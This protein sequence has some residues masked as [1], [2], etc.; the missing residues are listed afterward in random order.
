MDLTAHRNK[1]IEKARAA[2]LMAILPEDCGA[3]ALDVGAR[4][5]WYS[6]LL[7][8]RFDKVTALDLQM[9]NIR[10]PKIECVKGN[11]VKLDFNDGEFELIFCTE[12][13]EHIPTGQLIKVCSEIERV[14]SKYIIIGVPFKQDIRVARTKCYT[15]G[16]R[17]PPWGHINSFDE[18]YLRN[19]FSKCDVKKISF[20][21]NSNECT[22]TLSVFLMDFAGNPYGTYHQE[23]P[24][25]W[26][27][28]NLKKPP[29]RTI[30]QKISTK[31][32]FFIQNLQ[33]T[34]HRSHPNWIHI[35]FK[36]RKA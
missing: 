36:K 35:L 31:M 4:D 34:F 17:N 15:C 12:V 16:K 33:K 18:N 9:P 14:A 11:A 27:G 2:D 28:A 7:A 24:C 6:V 30:T 3:N 10:H 20:V 13:L 1:D 21:G 23:E 19:L 26:C 29:S 22:N 5:G 32:A 8:N 25:I